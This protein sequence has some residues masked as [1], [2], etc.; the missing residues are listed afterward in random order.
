VT[1]KLVQHDLSGTHSLSFLK[2]LPDDG[3]SSLDHRASD[4]SFSVEKHPIAAL[5]C[6]PLCVD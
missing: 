3:I 6:V 4:L 5:A 1:I 2:L